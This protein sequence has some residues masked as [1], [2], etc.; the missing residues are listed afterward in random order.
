M[1]GP[2][3]VVVDGRGLDLRSARQL[4]VLAVLVLHARRTVPA[5]LLIRALWQEWPPAAARGSLHAHLSRLRAALAAHGA[6]GCLRTEAAGYVLD[7]AP[8]QV[9]AVVFEQRVREARRRLPDDPGAALAILDDALALWRGP[10]YAGIVEH[11]PVRGEATRLEELRLGAI[12]DRTDALLAL[13]RHAEALPDLERAV[14]RHPLRERPRGQLMLARHRAGRTVEAL[15]AF[16]RLRRMLAEEYGLDPSP[17]LRRLESEL[18]RGSVGPT[19]RRPPGSRARLTSF[20]GREADLAE[21]DRV[22]ADTRL[23][24]LTG[25]GGAGKSRLAAELADRV[26]DRFSDGVRTVELAPARDGAAVVDAFARELGVRRQGA[27]PLPDTLVAALRPRRVL[28]VVDNCEH[29]LDEVAALVGRIVRDCA[30]VSV[31]ATSRQRLAVAGEHL[32]PVAPLAVPADGCTTP[33]ALGRVASVRL[34]RDRASAADPSFRLDDGT[35]GPVAHI[36]RRLDGLPLAIELAAA[37]VAALRPADLAVRLDARFGLLTGGRRDDTGRHRTLRATIDWSY[38]LL[39]PAEAAL[40]ARL[41]VFRGG[42]DLVAVESV[43]GSDA[44]RVDTA[45]LL[46][47]LVDKS[48]VVAAPSGPASR[49]RLLETLRDHGAELLDHEE[50]ARVERAHAT[51]FVHLAEAADRDVRGREE[52]RGVAAI[53]RDLSNL[54]AAHRWAIR[55]G[56]ADLALRLCAAL[57]FYAIHRLH[58]EVLGW[59]VEATELPA[60]EGHP[61]RASVLASVAF[62]AAH[63]GEREAARALAR[64]G[65]TAA[66]DPA[67]RADVLETL[68]VLDIYEGRLADS[69]RHGATAVATARRCGDAYRAQWSSHV[70]ALAATYAGDRDTPELIEAV[71]VGAR[72]L[73]NP[74]QVAWAAYLQGEAL[75]DRDPQRA[76]GLLDEAI[77]LAAPVGNHFVHGVSLVSA[78][79]AGGRSSDPHAAIAPFRDAIDHW[80]RAG[81][82]THQWTT[83]RNLVEVLARIGADEAAAVV[84]AAGA[85]SPVAPPVF[86]V[87][88]ERLAGAERSL[89]QRLGPDRFGRAVERG[90]G[91]DDDAVVAFALEV[92]NGL[93]APSS[94]AGR[95]LGR[96]QVLDQPGDEAAAVEPV[97][98][99]DERLQ[100][101]ADE[102]ADRS[103]IARPGRVGRGGDPS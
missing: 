83:L 6:G 46:A 44:G 69:R 103:G 50:S 7:V 72:D 57:H 38:E 82:R 13:D 24:T 59:G 70:T 28:L 12:D 10:A 66:C 42:F 48:M 56:D 86:G 79:S 101:P 31:L 100:L 62:G 40:F 58:D 65:L 25:T 74:S 22:L 78:G 17:A 39:D 18:L 77:A 60:A 14:A 8:E 91:L 41:S 68:A 2:V 5:E 85:A 26:A 88:A 45:G 97:P 9:D 49:Y 61:L 33:D 52:A 80:S 4:T 93:G 34:F 27:T 29:V 53:A 55:T 84:L 96:E 20:V 81:D 98:D 71:V 35:A 37:R 15:E 1:L 64:R 3:D 87:G 102:L 76:A 63:R 89:R 99:L 73:G 21:L 43:C 67:G 16:H 11:E 32:R 95:V 92:L 23:V 75:L 51:Y 19:S 90:R 47:A 30:R 94:P 36:C 54:R